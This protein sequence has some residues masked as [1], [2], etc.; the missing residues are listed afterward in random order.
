MIETYIP[1][2]LIRELKLSFPDRLPTK[3]EYDNRTVTPEGIAFAAGIQHV[4]RYL[5]AN[6][7]IQKAKKT[8]EELQI[9][10]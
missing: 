1:E 6:S 4:I 9:T 3:Q 10:M 7:T 2:T 5:E 8:R